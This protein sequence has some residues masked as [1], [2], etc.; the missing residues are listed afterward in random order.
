MLCG[1]LTYLLDSIRDFI[2]DPPNPN[3]NPM[4]TLANDENLSTF[5]NIQGM[6]HDLHI[7]QFL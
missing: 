1:Y 7:S 3:P 6:V 4:P 5:Q 2:S